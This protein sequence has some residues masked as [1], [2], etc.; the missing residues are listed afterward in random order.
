MS[1]RLYYRGQLRANG[2]PKD[3]QQIRRILHPQLKAL[4]RQPPL[5]DFCSENRS[6]L[7]A[8]NTS[9]AVSVIYLL[10][11]FNF[12]CLVTE[13]LRL[14]AE[15]DIL[16]LR[17]SAP[18]ALIR[19]G[20]DIDNRLKTLFDGL[21]RPLESSELP[22]GDQPSVNEEPFH[23][24]LADDALISKLSVTTD[25][26]LEFQDPDEVVLIICVTVVRSP[27]TFINFNYI[28]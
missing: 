24:L 27:T 18:G 8:A 4:W 25:Q 3:K 19:T 10:D 20:G 11:G 9:D 5:S 16:F 26:L 12:A 17:P 22:I 15:L 13:R 21:R 28:S 7:A 14:H 23:C 1:F 6:Y 2:S